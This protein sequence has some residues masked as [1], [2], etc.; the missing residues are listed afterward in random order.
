MQHAGKADRQLVALS[1]V[2]SWGPDAQNA[3]SGLRSECHSSHIC[4]HKQ[5]EWGLGWDITS[6]QWGQ[7][8]SAWAGGYSVTLL[9]WSWTAVWLFPLQHRPWLQGAAQHVSGF[10][11]ESRS[12]EVSAGLLL[13]RG[14]SQAGM[15]CSEHFR[16]I[17]EV[18]VLELGG[19]KKSWWSFKLW[20]CLTY[21]VLCLL[22]CTSV[23]QMLWGIWD[24]PSRCT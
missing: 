21:K 12:G 10:A 1:S 24:E 19:G 5:N 22:C 13:G 3:S 16:G 18:E 11:T 7:I 20:K 8:L 4:C 14:N 6:G 15:W 17:Y 9:K 2:P 23:S